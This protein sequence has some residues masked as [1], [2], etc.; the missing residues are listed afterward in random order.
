[1][2]VCVFLFV[3]LF[4]APSAAQS[5]DLNHKHE[6]NPSSP[7]GGWV[8]DHFARMVRI[9]VSGEEYREYW[10]KKWGCMGVCSLEGGW[11]FALVKPVGWL[12]G[13]LGRRTVV[14]LGRIWWLRVGFGVVVVYKTEVMR[15]S[16]GVEYW[17]RY[18]YVFGGFGLLCV[19][20]GSEECSDF[21][22]H[23]AGKWMFDAVEL[24]K[25]E[26]NGVNAHRLRP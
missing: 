12:E 11:G 22:W 6:T 5:A 4:V 24:R 23:G 25:D 19:M 9:M 16:S 21:I 3:C 26:W 8:R 14:C 1:M 2:R 13:A 15:G 10:V 7:A 18:C 20:K 17:S